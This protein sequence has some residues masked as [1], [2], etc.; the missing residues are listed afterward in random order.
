MLDTKTAAAPPGPPPAKNMKW[1]PGRTFLMGSDLAQ[2]PE[3]GPPHQVTVDGFW[4]DQ[5]QVTVEEF[6]KFVRATGYKTVAERPL[7]PAMYPDLDPQQLLPGSMVFQKAKGPVDLTSI[8]NWWAWVPGACWKHPEGPRATST[9]ARNTPSCT[10]AGR[11]SRR[12]QPGLARRSPPRPS[13]RWQRRGGLEGAIFTWGNEENPKGRYLA[14]HWQGEFPHQNLRRDGYEGTAPVGSF[15]PN[16]YGLYDMA[17]N[18]WEWTSDFFVPRHADEMSH[19]CCV[20][21]NPRIVS[22]D[23]SYDK[24]DPGASHI[25]RKVIKGGSHLCAPNYC[26]RYRPAARQPQMVETGM[27]HIGFRCIVR[28]KREAGE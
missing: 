17:G 16:G 1:V 28:P 22:P 11:T 23:A 10:S 21:T 12:T 7:D 27:A 6:R 24:N 25:P 8:H 18:V 26:L 9:S 3:E 2:Y 19:A 4:I 15:P 14:N 20:P 5:Y 13:G